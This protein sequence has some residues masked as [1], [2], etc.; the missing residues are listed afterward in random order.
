MWSLHPPQI[1]P[2]QKYNVSVKSSKFLKFQEVLPRTSP[3][4]CLARNFQ[5]LVCSHAVQHLTFTYAYNFLCGHHQPTTCTYVI[6]PLP[7]HSLTTTWCTLLMRRS[8]LSNKTC[9]TVGTTWLQSGDP[10]RMVWEV[11]TEELVP[12]LSWAL[13]TPWEVEIVHFTSHGL[14]RIHINQGGGDKW[15]T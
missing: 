1:P 14:M 2:M 9:S 6:F 11:V 3:P 10:H 5:S 8:A 12:K 4:L 13:T 15:F 7:L